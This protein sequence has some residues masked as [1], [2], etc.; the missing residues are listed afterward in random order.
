MATKEQFL[1]KLAGKMGR[2][3]IHEVIK[4]RWLR[5]PWDHLH[6][7]LDQ[8]GIASLFEQELTKLGG[9]VIR[10]ASSHELPQAI[11]HFMKN[12]DMT[13][14]IAWPA[15]EGEFDP[16]KFIQQ[17]ADELNV[18]FWSTEQSRETL[19]EQADH[20]HAGLVYATHG[21]AETG[22]IVLYN[23]GDRGRLVSLLPNQVLAVLR[24]SDIVPRL[25]QVLAMAEPRAIDTS[26]IN[27]ITGP[28]R[29]SDIEMDLTIGVHGPGRIAIFLIEDHHLSSN[30]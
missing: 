22:S 11:H 29:T 1:N 24:T 26:C 25:T 4:P 2:D 19:I 13:H 12:R 30:H 21:I 9:D 27:I 10:V 8:D 3:R 5:H 7:G 17:E 14:L 20:C 18:S 15:N 6:Q 16:A 28:S 23:R